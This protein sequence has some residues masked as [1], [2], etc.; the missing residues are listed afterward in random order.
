[1]LSVAA[2][3]EMARVAPAA[4]AARG[5]MLPMMA[6]MPPGVRHD[7]IVNAAADEKIRP[8]VPP[9]DDERQQGQQAQ[10]AQQER[11][12]VAVGVTS[13]AGLKFTSLGGNPFTLA[14]KE[15]IRR[16]F[17]IQVGEFSGLAN[18]TFDGR[19]GLYRDSVSR[20]L[21]VQPAGFPHENSMGGMLES[22]GSKSFE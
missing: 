12:F 4:A 3:A 5:G 1:R 19:A 22:N 17:Q 18:L 16:F 9:I 6:P 14:A 15:R 7:R 13:V 20:K 2:M 8:A 21:D 10:Q 11:A